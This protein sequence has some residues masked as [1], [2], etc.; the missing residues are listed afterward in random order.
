MIFLSA[1]HNAKAAFKP[2]PGAVGNG[3]KEGLLT[4]ELRDLVAAEL[5]SMGVSYITDTDNE[6]L[7]QYLNRIKPG[8]ASV[9]IEYHFNAASPEAT[10]TETIIG[11]DADRFD[12]AFAKEL[13]DSTANII[14]INN[15]G[16]KKEKESHRGRLGLMRKQGIVALPEVCF[17]SNAEDM[18]KYQATKYSLA[19]AHAL[20]I[21]KYEEMIP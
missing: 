15:R 9:V 12:T 1:G 18:R 21:K 14:G 10:G 19:K 11:D 8:N 13:T 17:I 16:V 7:S 5:K 6:T 3:F 2:D 4:I 20:I